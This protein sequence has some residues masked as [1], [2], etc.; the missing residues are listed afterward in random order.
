EALEKLDS[1]PDIDLVLMDIQMPVM[2]GLQAT[3]VLRAAGYARPIVALTANVMADDVQRYLEGGCT[4]CLGK[5]IDFVALAAMLAELLGNSG[6]PITELDEL[7]EMQAL[8]G[9]FA[10]SLPDRLARMAAAVQAGDWAALADEAHMLKGSAASFG[11]PE[12]GELA[13]AIDVALRA[14]DPAEAARQVGI[15]RAL[16]GVVAEEGA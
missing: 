8:R 11:H 9:L 14:G 1:A 13:R 15:L 5:P 7:A 10:D 16:Y 12:A 4:R 2:D 3:A 6:G